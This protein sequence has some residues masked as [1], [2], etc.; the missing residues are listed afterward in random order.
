MKKIDTAYD[1]LLKSNYELY[2][3]KFSDLQKEARSWYKDVDTS[4]FDCRTKYSLEDENAKYTVMK[5]SG[6]ASNHFYAYKDQNGKMLLMDGFNRLLTNYGDL[7]VDPIVYIKVLTDDLS[8]AKLMNIMFRL[9][10]WK[11]SKSGQDDS[12]FWT[13]NFLDRGFR[14]FMFTKFDIV[15]KERHGIGY[16][17]RNDMNALDHYFRNESIAVYFKRRLPELF[18]LFGNERIVDDF[19][20]ILKIHDYEEAP[21][22]NYDTFEEGFIRFLARRRLVD[23]FSEHKFET[24]IKLLEDDKKFFKKLQGMS[25]NDS[26]RKNVYE[27]FKNIEKDLDMSN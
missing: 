20:E 15:L 9:N 23:D 1:E 22:K 14:L 7:P 11:I 8:D 4:E 26:T 27:F 25:G 3:V 6:I 10:M 24:Y 16:Y 19:K 17:G 12:E 13:S 2:S 5:I 18:K 21:F